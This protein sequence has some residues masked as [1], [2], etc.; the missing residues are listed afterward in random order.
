MRVAVDED[1]GLLEGDCQ[2]AQPG[3]DVVESVRL[4]VGLDESVRIAR[5]RALIARRVETRVSLPD[6]HDGC[7]LLGTRLVEC[8]LQPLQVCRVA[9]RVLGEAS[10]KKSAAVM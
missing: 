7:R 2:L 10:A 5:R 4:A 9:S 1:D 8:V 6:D 3:E